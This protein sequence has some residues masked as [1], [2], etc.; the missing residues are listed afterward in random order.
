MKLESGDI[1]RF[2]CFGNT[3]RPWLNRIGI[4]RTVQ[5]I[6]SEEGDREQYDIDT[7][8]V[9]IT[10]TSVPGNKR[11]ALGYINI[12]NTGIIMHRG[13][14]RKLPVKPFREW[15]IGTLLQPLFP[16]EQ[17]IT[18]DFM[19]SCYLKIGNNQ[20]YDIVLGRVVSSDMEQNTLACPI[21]TEI[22]IN[23]PMIE[24]GGG[25][26]AE[27]LDPE[28]LSVC[29]PK[30][31]RKQTCYCYGLVKVHFQKDICLNGGIFDPNGCH[32]T[33]YLT[34]HGE[35]LCRTSPG[36]FYNFDTQQQRK[37]DTRFLVPL[38]AEVQVY[39]A[40]GKTAYRTL[41]GLDGLFLKRLD[42]LF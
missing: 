42:G 7:N 25:N 13:T 22:D 41:E 1:I 3:N 27:I 10:A 26:A 12:R 33:F 40:V 37:G 31:I 21:Q 29:C 5:S 2:Q 30:T 6:P 9:D 15:P 14:I 23:G 4:I 28:D 17:P 39:G 35:F 36:K 18:L 8:G 24:Q 16:R 19:A 11:G 38:S 20:V 32:D 34:E